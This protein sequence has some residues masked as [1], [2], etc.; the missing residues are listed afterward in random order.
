MID[1]LVPQWLSDDVQSK[2]NA[3]DVDTDKAAELLTGIGFKKGD[4]GKWVDDK[5]AALAF[6]LEFPS[7]YTDWSA[8][9]EN[10]L[11][12][13]N[14]FGFNITGNAVVST[15]QVQDVYDGNFQMAIRDWGAA[16]P[17][18]NLSYLVPY[19]TYDGQGTVAGEQ[20]GGGMH[21]D[22]KVTYSG[23]DIDVLDTAVKAGQGLDQDAQK[24]LVEQ[25]A[26]SYNELLPAIPLWER[27]ANNPL[28]RTHLDAPA[29]DDAI[30]KNPWSGTDAFM[31]Y[32]ITTGKVAPAAAS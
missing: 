9:A 22:T 19:Q 28:N 26:L 27:Y 18:A 24:A 21:F 2:L 31:P 4:D 15:Q 5:G 8:A 14:A 1:A 13:L 11:E 25:L 3:Y 30:F 12:Q 10:A 16:S 32:L 20:K 7:D 17:F 23:G 6:T 29:S